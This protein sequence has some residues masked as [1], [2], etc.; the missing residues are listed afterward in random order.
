MNIYRINKAPY[1]TDPL[2]VIGSQ[3]YGGRWNPR[4]TGILYTARSPELA[5]LET[6]VHLPPLTLPELP[7][8]WLSTLRLPDEPNLVFWLEPDRLPPY[9]QTGTLAE[10]GL[11]M[12]DWLQNPFA[13][14]V[15]VPSAILDEA[16]NILLHPA[17]PA[18]SRVEVLAQR[19]IPLDRRLVRV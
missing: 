10:T 7:Q 19:P 14:A 17:H 6:I 8:L 12:S 9:W 5:L 16:Y 13:L 3:R 2:S 15:A 1:H 18:F 4:G 11:I